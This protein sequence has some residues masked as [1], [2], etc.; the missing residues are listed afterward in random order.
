[1]TQ[2]F[3]GKKVM[4]PLSGGINS[5]AVLCW[6]IGNH[7]T[8]PHEVHLYYAHF[9]EHSDDTRL[10]VHDLVALSARSFTCRVVYTETH[11][12]VLEYFAGENMIP[13]PMVSPCS[14]NL[15]I[16]PMRAYAAANGIDVELIGYV[17][18]EQRRVERQ[19]KFSHKNTLFD[20]YTE[21]AYPLL[22]Y[23]NEWCFDIVKRHL[24]WYPA[25]YDIRRE[26]GG[27][28]LFPH[29]NCLPCK[30]MNGKDFAAVQKFFPLH[31]RKAQDLAE[32]IQSYWGRQ[33]E[34]ERR[35]KEKTEGPLMTAFG[36]EDVPEELTCA[37]CRY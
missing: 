37:H 17:R 26:T 33:P 21:K 9:E 23:N 12:S 18:E 19:D 27:G 22:E 16:K 10:F 11:N 29:N 34:G 3:E 13:H 2:T 24:G 28:R 7:A 36:A 32:R 1:M 14:L 20:A 4:I 6:F 15:K 25:I 5:A 31:Y 35:T 8:E 30:N